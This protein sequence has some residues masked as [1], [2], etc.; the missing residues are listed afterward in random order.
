MPNFVTHVAYSGTSNEV[1][2]SQPQPHKTIS[3]QAYKLLSPEDRNEVC[4]QCAS[5]IQSDTPHRGTSVSFTPNKFYYLS[6][7]AYTNLAITPR[8]ASAAIPRL[9]FRPGQYNFNLPPYL[10]QDLTDRLPWPPKTSDFIPERR[11]KR[12]LNIDSSDEAALASIIDRLRIPH[13]SDTQQGKAGLALELILR[14][15]LHRGPTNYTV[16]RYN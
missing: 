12:A 1:W 16:P 5:A 13:R 15:W 10:L 14:G 9:A 8:R 6:D 11:L 4:L 2:C 3:L 7:T